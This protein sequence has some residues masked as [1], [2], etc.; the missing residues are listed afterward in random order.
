MRTLMVK[1]IIL[2]LSINY[3]F[4][5]ITVESGLYQTDLNIFF[6]NDLDLT[7]SGNSPL[8]FWIKITNHYTVSK[9]VSLKMTIL[10]NVL[11]DADPVLAFGETET[12]SLDPG[13][14]IITN[15]NLFSQL[16]QYKF[17]NYS[18]N[19]NAA[20]RL[21][22]KILS[23]G[24]LPSGTYIFNIEITD[25]SPATGGTSEYTDIIINI[26]NP[27]TLDLIAPG[28]PAGSSELTEIYTTLPLFHWESDA[29]EFEIK[30]CEKLSTHNS[31]ED[32]M[33]NEPHLLKT[34]NNQKIFQYPSIDARLLE[35]GKAY[36][37]QVTAL[38]LSSGGIERLP[39]EIWGFKIAS[40]SSGSYSAFQIQIVNNL[41]ALLG[42]DFIKGLFEEGGQ[43]ANFFPTGVML[44][45]GTSM[46][47]E[48][49]NALVDKVLAGEIKIKG[50]SVE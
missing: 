37:W 8:L 27:T 35:E 6:I 7:Q 23:T 46:T 29:S 47:L 31:P 18:I 13:T 49:L 3:S 43:L 12:Y 10:Q 14:L 5:Q 45:D 50:Y 40:L 22:E 11:P 20:E 32:V 38:V 42:A 2:L 36:Y 26:S 39:S 9:L 34:V 1:M 16:D 41:I 19:H 33:S 28:E 21:I 15:Q 24:K 25:H 4:A 48:D 44:K 30:V 17:E